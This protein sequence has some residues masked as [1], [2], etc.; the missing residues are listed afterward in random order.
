MKIASE[1]QTI[2]RKKG[3]ESLKEA[4][5]KDRNPLKR[6]KKRIEILVFKALK[7]DR[8]PLKTPQKRIGL[9][10]KTLKKGWIGIP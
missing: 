5:Q 7:K 6:L 10:L 2:L 8:N 3:W 4:K 1:N 9:P